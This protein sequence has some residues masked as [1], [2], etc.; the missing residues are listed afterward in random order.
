MWSWAY[1]TDAGKR[2]EMSE[3][4]NEDRAHSMVK[5]GVLYQIVADGNGLTEEIN[6]AAFV[7]NEIERFIDVYSEEGMNLDEIRRMLL[8]AIYCAN[9]V[10]IAYKRADIDKYASNVFSTICVSAITSNNEFVYAWSGD[11]RVYLIRD[12]RMLPISTDHTEAQR[13]YN[14]GKITREEIFAHPERDILTSAIGFDNPKIEILD[15]VL[16]V[17]D[18]VLM[19][20]DG[21]HKMLQPQQIIDVV[22]AAGNCEDTCNALIQGGNLQGGVDNMAVTVAYV[23]A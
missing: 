17:G 7:I 14:E 8:G 18:I 19:M 16:N 22:Q 10:L 15:A 9:R 20:T 6:P 5:N 2:A 13:L 4:Q 23:S 12:K 11:S 3:K 1:S 21:I